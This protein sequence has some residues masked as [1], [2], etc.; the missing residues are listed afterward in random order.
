[1]IP[2]GIVPPGWR[3][4]LLGSAGA[5][6]LSVFIPLE[7]GLPEGALL[8]A[9]L[10]LAEYPST[11]AVDQINQ[12][13]FEAGVELWPGALYY[14]FVTAEAPSL[15]IAW[16]KGMVWWGIILAVLGTVLL[17]P[18]LTSVVWW[19][20]PE[21]IKTMIE[22]IAMMGVMLLMMFVMTKFLKPLGSQ[23][24]AKQIKEA[25]K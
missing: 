20:L 8:L 10:D 1:M 2:K 14:A 24:K 9:R 21:G 11:D 3:A 15:Y 4:V 19:I 16:S 18:L 7:E 17:P 22:S 6:D 13:L 23:P 12:S 25:K 5:E